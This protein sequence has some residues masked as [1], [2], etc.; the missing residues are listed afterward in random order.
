MNAINA[1]ALESLE[2]INHRLKDAGALFHLCEVK[3]P[4]MELMSGHAGSMCGR[5]PGMGRLPAVSAVVSGCP[6]FS[7]PG[8]SMVLP[9]VWEEEREAYPLGCQVFDLIGRLL[10]A[11]ARNRRYQQGLFQAAA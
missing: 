8:A 3:G 5:A 9:W 10:V 1:G 6:G 7:F 11:G 4:V 2:A